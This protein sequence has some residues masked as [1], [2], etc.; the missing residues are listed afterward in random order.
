MT[1]GDLSQAPHDLPSPETM[2]S[3]LPSRLQDI[4]GENPDHYRLEGAAAALPMNLLLKQPHELR[5]A[6]IL[7]P[8]IP[9]TNGAHVILTERQQHL[10]NHA[11]QVAFPG[12]S[13]E[14][15]DPSPS[16][17]A[18]R[19][20]EEEVGI[21]PSTVTVL[22]HLPACCTM[23]GFC[24]SPVVG[25]LNQDVCLRP[26]TEEV[27]CIFEVP[28]SYLADPGNR[29]K[30]YHRFGDHEI[31]YYIFTYENHTI[32]GMTAAI[33]VHLLETIQSLSAAS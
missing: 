25:W 23:S 33:L 28:L 4:M 16:A 14:P 21:D 13:V 9:R 1:K 5:R 20:A 31:A 26:Q 15:G 30:K 19:E 6:A 32:W 11:G 2:L 3:L 17:A 7:I 24:V 22:G 12:G 10:S 27:A 18:L 29:K 8:I